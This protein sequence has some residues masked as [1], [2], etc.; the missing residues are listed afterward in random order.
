[1]FSP[2]VAAQ[3]AASVRSSRRR[4]RTSESTD[5]PSSK[6]QRS[7][8]SDQTFVPPADAQEKQDAL[9]KVA[10]ANLASAREPSGSQ[11]EMAVR[12]KK[13][14]SGERAHKGDGSTILVRISSKSEIIIF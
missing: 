8:L 6:R 14:R 4:Q 9:K 1:M 2:A 11:R 10:L 5:Q 3:Q 7:N 12:A 13:S